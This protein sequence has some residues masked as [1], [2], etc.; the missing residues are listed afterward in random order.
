MATTLFEFHRGDDHGIQLTITDANDQA[1]DITGWSFKATM[2]LH[3]EDSDD[4]APVRV[5]G[6]PVSGIN[7]EAGKATILLPSTQT[8]NLLPTHYWLDVQR[9]F[10]GYVGTVFSGRVKVL[11]DVTRRNG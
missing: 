4:A 9:E 6:D 7:A 3:T 5:D 10:N 1:V 2:K 8:A 11:P